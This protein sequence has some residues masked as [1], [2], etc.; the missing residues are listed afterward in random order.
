LNVHGE[1]NTAVG[2]NSL[3]SNT[4]GFNTAVG[5]N[6]LVDNTTG[7]SNTA[8]GAFAGSELTTGHDNLDLDNPGVAGE[9]NTVRIG[10]SF[11]HNRTFIGAVRGVTAGN[12]NAVPVFIDS[13]GQLGTISSSARFKKDI[14]AMAKASEAILALKPVTFHYKS[15]KQA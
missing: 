6:A 4:A 12:N 14:T 9:S 8:I 3:P 5:V 7:D 15:D 1:D 13:A 10:N 11:V 2:F